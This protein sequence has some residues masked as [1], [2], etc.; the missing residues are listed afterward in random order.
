ML[1]WTLI[2]ATE[3]AEKGG[4]F[5]LNATLP[6]IALQFLALVFILDRLFYQP[7]T[8]TIDQRNDSIRTSLTKAK[9]ETE[10]ANQ[11]AQQFLAE[12]SQARV[13]AQQV[14]AEAEASAQAIRAEKVAAAQAEVQAKLDE[15]QVAVEQEKQQALQQLEQQV[16]ALSQQM[17]EKLL[18]AAAKG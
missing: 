6:L 9:Q 18:G 1:H 10:A 11:L 12:T 16:D 8:R 4:L 7:V 5:D 13:Q 3:A 17:I 2:L 15:A 14:I